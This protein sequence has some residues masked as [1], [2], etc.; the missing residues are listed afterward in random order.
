M[1]NKLTLLA[2]ALAA[3][4]IFAGCETTK[5]TRTQKEVSDDDKP[6]APLA[7]SLRPSLSE[8]E[9]VNL[10]DAIVE[11]MLA[12]IN[13]DNY[14]LYSEN[15]FKGL[16]D[17]V[18]EKDFKVINADLKKQIGEYQSKSYM[19]MLNKPMVDVFFWKAKFSNTKDDV[20]IR[21][22]LI[23]EDGKYKVSSFSIGPY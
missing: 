16:K 5:E 3:L 9:K 13:K 11:R 2:A 6:K 7:E 14:G 8:T 10:A 18:K 15:F 17:Q 19:G 4:A 20:L 12:G 1:K 23:E 22:F 21:L